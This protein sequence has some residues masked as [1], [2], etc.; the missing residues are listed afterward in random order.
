MVEE[1]ER[2]L[3]LSEAAQ[4]LGI[5]EENLKRLAE[6]GEVSAYK[7]GGIFLR[8]KV[9]QLTAIK[10]YLK[11]KLDSLASKP[12]KVKVIPEQEKYTFLERLKD[13]WHFYDFYVIALLII[14][15]IL[16]VIFKFRV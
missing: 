9:E 10:P 8:F 3:S 4:F 16:Y 5:S 7:I 12:K 1:K 11:E 6:E 13:F 15:F 2:L 14:I